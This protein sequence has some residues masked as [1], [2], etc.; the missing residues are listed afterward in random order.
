MVGLEAVSQSKEPAMKAPRISTVGWNQVA[1]LSAAALGLSLTCS[2]QAAEPPDKI[3]LVGTVRDFVERTKPNGHPDMEQVPNHGY[4]LYNKTVATTLGPNG[5]PFFTQNGKKLNSPFRDAA[6]LPIC[7]NVYQQ[8]PQPGDQA[9]SFGS[10]DS[11]G[12]E[13][14][15]TF[16][17]W[18]TDVPGVNLSAPL[19]L[20]FDRQPNGQYVFDDKLDPYY[21]DLG[22]FFPID[23]QLLGNS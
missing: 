6:G 10:S 2:G 14:A 11:G 3:E 5:R 21:V 20:S 15:T 12:I 8:Y 16:E 22:G 23:D 9:G 1:A 18:F 17:Q 7:Y 19:T 4:G 13:S